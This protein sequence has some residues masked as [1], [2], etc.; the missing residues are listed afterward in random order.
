MRHEYGSMTVIRLLA[1]IYENKNENENEKEKLF[2][3]ARFN[4]RLL[5]IPCLYSF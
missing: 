3:L 4:S 2:V 1:Y 5:A